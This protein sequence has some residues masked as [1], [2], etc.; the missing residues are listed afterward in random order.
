MVASHGNRMHGKDPSLPRLAETA[1]KGTFAKT[2]LVTAL[3]MYKA[4]MMPELSR[5]VEARSHEDPE[6]M[7]EF[8]TVLEHGLYMHVFS[9]ASG[10]EGPS[11]FQGPH[12]I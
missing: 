7:E 4:G 2:H 5:V 1:L 8:K 10:G 6:E 12:G 9:M 11:W 3:Q